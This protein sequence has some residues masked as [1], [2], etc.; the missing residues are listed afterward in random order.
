MSVC[1]HCQESSVPT[2]DKLVAMLPGTTYRC[3]SCR[4]LID[5]DRS[6]KLIFFG[7]AVLPFVGELLDLWGNLFLGGLVT[8]AGVTMA[9]LALLRAPLVKVE[10]A[11]EP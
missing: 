1:P 11:A 8:L 6:H 4:R 3:R 5:V 2:I 7:F 10:G 9:A